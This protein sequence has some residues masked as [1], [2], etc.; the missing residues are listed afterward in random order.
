MPNRVMK[1]AIKYGFKPKP[2]P[3]PSTSKKINNPFSVKDVLVTGF[4]FCGAVAIGVAKQI[5][6]GGDPLLQ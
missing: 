3:A 5:F 6:L 4:L 1:C 2:N